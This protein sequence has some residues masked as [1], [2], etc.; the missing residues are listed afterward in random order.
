MLKFRK[1]N[2]LIKKSLSEKIVFGI[3]FALFCL[4]AASLLYPLVW[5]LL[6][7]LKHNLNY[8]DDLTKGIAFPEAGGW[9]FGNYYE[10]FNSIHYNNTNIFGMIFNSIWI[11]G[12]NLTISMFFSAC[13]GYALAKY[14]FR[15]RNL[16]Y[17]V[18]II[19]LT[20]P[21][22]GTGG[23]T[24]TFYYKTGMY[25]TPFYT[26]FSSISG[27]GVTFLMTYSFFKSVSWEYAEAVF[28][29][30]GND[31]TVF[32]K[33]MIPMALPMILTLMIKDFIGLW[34]AYEGP[35]MYLPSYPTLAVGIFMVGDFFDN[36]KPV[37][38]AAMVISII[39]MITLFIVFSDMFMKNLSIGGLKG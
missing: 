36:D 21:I 6:N 32:F 5:L 27:F 28:L 8:I 29:D 20:L 24:Y 19:C 2:I 30:G 22:F 26:L 31:F 34:N 11:S 14:Q 23:A 33:I 18:A 38:Y 13:T 16:I 39:P 15:G 25:D 17:S 1:K 10:A 12:L 37:Y 4:W 35:L 3:F 9:E 7:S